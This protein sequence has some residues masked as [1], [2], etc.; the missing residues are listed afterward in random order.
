MV[1]DLFY[2]NILVNFIATGSG[3]WTLINAEHFC[4]RSRFETLVITHKRRVLHSEWAK[5]LIFVIGERFGTQ[6][7]R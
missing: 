4:S 7:D 5:R 2:F 1:E 3:S 6:V